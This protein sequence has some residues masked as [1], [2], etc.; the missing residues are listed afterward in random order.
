MNV[1]MKIN[2]ILPWYKNLIIGIKL[3]KQI[4]LF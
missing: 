4:F 3:N 1:D 2:N